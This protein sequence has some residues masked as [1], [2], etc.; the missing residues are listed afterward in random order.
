MTNFLRNV[1]SST[2]VSSGGAQFSFVPFSAN[3]TVGPRPLLSSI[4]D[5]N[6]YLNNSLRSSPA[7]STN[8]QRCAFDEGAFSVPS[9]TSKASLEMG[10]ATSPLSQSLPATQSEIFLRKHTFSVAP[11]LQD[12]SWLQADVSNNRLFGFSY[13]TTTLSYLSVSPSCS[14][15][16]QAVKPE[17]NRNGLATTTSLDVNSVAVSGPT[18]YLGY[19][20]DQYARYSIGNN[21]TISPGQSTTSTQPCREKFCEKRPQTRVAR[22][23]LRQ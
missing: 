19:L 16:F 18:G 6:V 12:I 17:D 5:I 9:T 14:K 15:K 2:T 21:A 13:G 20:R 3:G 22:R 4:A 23:R 10:A 11:A 7:D 1:A 8:L